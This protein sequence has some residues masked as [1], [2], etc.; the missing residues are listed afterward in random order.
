MKTKYGP[1]PAFRNAT[2]ARLRA[3]GFNALGA[4]A[5]EKLWDQ[6]FPYTI[7]LD[8]TKIETAPKIDGTF[9]PDVFDPAWARAIDQQAKTLCVPRRDS[10]DLIGYFSDNELS[11]AQVRASSDVPLVFD[12]S[13]TTLR[14]AQKPSLLQLCLA[15]PAHSAAWEFVLTRHNND[16]AAVGRA[17]NVAGLDTRARL[18]RWTSAGRAV[19]SAGYV[20]D[21]E[22]FSALF[23]TRYFRLASEAIRRHDPH[24]LVLGCRFGGEPGPAVLAAMKRPFVDVLSANNYRHTLFERVDGYARATGLPVLIG[25]FAW[26]TD[27]FLKI[28]LG[29]EPMGGFPALERMIVKGEAVLEKAWAHPA[30]VGYA[31]YRW[32]DK[33]DFT[34]PISYGLVSV[35]DEPN[36]THLGVLKSI[37]ERAEVL[38]VGG[39]P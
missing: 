29:R 3:W 13:Q 32:V 26:V 23:A 18:A 8:F 37:H 5:D 22:A 19:L 27:Y 7:N 20:K 36:W 16:L 14:E 30:F 33:A 39:A 6:G 24:H 28:P 15:L 31:W 11:W 10:R 2:F 1:D 35:A 38:A 4:W 12:P 9:L 17:W 34:P 25:E 21:D